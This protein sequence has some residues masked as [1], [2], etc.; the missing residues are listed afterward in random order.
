MRHVIRDYTREA[1]VRNLE[2]KIATICRKTAYRIVTGVEKAAH[3]TSSNL[4]DYLGPVIYLETDLKARA[5]IGIVTGLAWTSVGGEVLKVE[6]LVTR[7]KGVLTLTGQLGDVMK[8]SATAGYTFIRSRSDKLKLNPKFY[9]EHDIHIHIPE[10]A[11]PKDGPSAGITMVTAMVSA[12]TGRKVKADLAMTGEITLSG[13]VLPI[14]GLKEKALAA[15]R[16]GIK[17]ILIPEKNIQDLEE[18]PKKVRNE[19]KFI[20]V[21]HMDQVLKLA[22]ED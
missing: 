21:S 19:I 11:I 5:E 15:H 17:T 6:V 2:R 7:G 9:E 1:G 3:V 16:Y 22:L 12:L 10:G 20:P 14:G 18:L 8:E 13:K 4:T